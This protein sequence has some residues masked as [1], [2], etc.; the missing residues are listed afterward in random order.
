MM[1]FQLWKTLKFKR[2]SSLVFWVHHVV[3]VGAYGVQHASEII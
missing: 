3:V 2:S 1:A